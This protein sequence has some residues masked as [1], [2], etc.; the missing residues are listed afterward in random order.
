MSLSSWALVM[1]HHREPD[2]ATAG[3]VYLVMASFGTLALL[4]AFGLLAGPRGEIMDLRAIRATPA[5]AVRGRAGL[6]PGVARRRLEGRPGAAARLAAAGASGSAEPCVGADERRHDQ[7]RDLR[8]R[9][10]GLR[11]SRPAAMVVERTDVDPWRRDR[12]DRPALGRT[13]GRPEEAPGLQHDR[14]YRHRVRR[15][16]PCARL[17]GERDA[18]GRRARHDR[19]A[20]PRPQSQHLQEPAVLRFRRRADGDRRARH[21]A[22][23]RPH[24][25]HAAHRLHVPCRMHGDLGAAAAQRLRLGVARSSRRSC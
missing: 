20:A 8:L 19:G 10:G 21:G 11:S 3:Y 16:R 2:N 9:A 15:A 22:S 17:Q 12:G 1:A 14:E 23:W 13:R 4:L 6:D 7:G 5:H 18:G 25:W 24:S